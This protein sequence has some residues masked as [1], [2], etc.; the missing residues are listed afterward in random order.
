MSYLFVQIVQRKKH[1]LQIPN[2]ALSEVLN[3][4]LKLLSTVSLKTGDTQH[5]P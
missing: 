1:I 5:L 4:S 3:A 2:Y